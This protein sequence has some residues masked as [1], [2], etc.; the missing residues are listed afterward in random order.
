MTGRSQSAESVPPDLG[1]RRSRALSF[2]GETDPFSKYKQVSSELVA[3]RADI[4][5]LERQ[6][7][8][9]RRLQELQINSSAHGAKGATAGSN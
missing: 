8:F 6:R 7:G 1:K 2:L 5:L 3:L 4:T 9:I